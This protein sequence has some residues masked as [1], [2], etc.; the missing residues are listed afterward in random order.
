[1]SLA[2]KNCAKLAVDPVN[3]QVRQVRAW[4]L[5][6]LSKT[7]VVQTVKQ[8]RASVPRECF[9]NAKIQNQ[10]WLSWQRLHTKEARAHGIATRGSSMRQVS[11]ALHKLETGTVLISNHFA[12]K[13]TSN[14]DQWCLMIVL[15]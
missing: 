9:C 4:H 15:H 7:V 10:I 1:M 13:A 14:Q 12:E 6:R 3:T 2:S 5:K 8:S 11:T